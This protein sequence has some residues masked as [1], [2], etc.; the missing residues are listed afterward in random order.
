MSDQFRDFLALSHAELKEL[1]LKAKEQRKA[2]VFMD[3]LQE[4]W[5][6][7]LG[8]TKGIKVVMVL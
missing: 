8:D 4:E 2:R 7:Y 1:N 6:K 3:R 5:L